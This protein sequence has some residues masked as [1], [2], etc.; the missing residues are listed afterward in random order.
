M[1]QYSP[2]SIATSVW[3][4]EAYVQ[5]FKSVALCVRTQS[6]L[7]QTDTRTDGRTDRHSSNVSEF[8]ADQMSPDSRSLFLGVT[9]VLTKLI[10]PLLG[11]YKNVACKYW[12]ISVL[13]QFY[14]ST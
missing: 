14:A 1:D 4:I 11:G 2:F 3:V 13:L 12:V 9:N 5:I 7:Q 8:C 6:C 10:Y